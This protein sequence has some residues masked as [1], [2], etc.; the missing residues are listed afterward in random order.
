M[1]MV[2]TTAVYWFVLAVWLVGEGWVV[3]SWFEKTGIGERGPGL[4]KKKT[5]EERGGERGTKILINA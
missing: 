1:F 3:P 2:S 4:L 5:S